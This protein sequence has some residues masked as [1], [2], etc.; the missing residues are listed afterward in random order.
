MLIFF[1]LV[2]TIDQEDA[3][4]LACRLWLHN[5]DWFFIISKTILEVSPIS[6]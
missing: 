4:P 2:T 1:N 6:W 5:K 3:T